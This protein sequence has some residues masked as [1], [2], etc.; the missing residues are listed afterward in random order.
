MAFGKA[1]DSQ[2]GEVNRVEAA[3]ALDQI[4][5]SRPFCNSHQCSGLLKY[6]VEHSLAGEE[7]LLR[8]RVI[9]AEIFGRPPGYEPAEDPVVRLRV[10]DV[11]KRLAQYYQSEADPTCMLVEI[12]P[13]SYRAIFKL[14]A[15]LPANLDGSEAGFLTGTFATKQ[16][17]AT[18][19][20]PDEASPRPVTFT[21]LN[22][23]FNSRISIAI[24]ILLLICATTA[25]V[26]L[27]RA[28]PEK[29]AFRAFWAPWTKSQKPV[30]ISV[31]S[32]AVYRFKFDYVDQYAKDH[33]IES[34]GQEVFLPFKDHETL[35]TSELDPA[36][37]SFVALS[38]V[39]AVSSIVA[40]LTRQNKAFQERFPDDISFAEL[41]VTPSVLVGGFNNPMA[42]ELTRHLEF[43]MRRGPEIDDVLNPGRK[44]SLHVP[45]GTPDTADYAILTRL[46]QR[47]GDA[48]LLSVAGLGGY[49]T[50]AAA[51]LISSPKAVYQL[52]NHLP[53]GWADKNLQVVMK[54]GITDFKVGSPEIVAYR[55]W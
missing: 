18:A 4:L 46:V 31:G 51:E 1:I 41:R 2:S 3:R 34:S 8:E 54:V 49:G 24:T 48:P 35:S 21:G 37:N 22:R 42:M 38:D 9:G 47:N 6:I 23:A 16:G 28:N 40:N 32:N 33:G 20:V 53:K 15:E 17:E 36:Y 11:R 43:V 39:A 45:V 29:G 7:N 25:T 27:L 52:A 14:R 30:I 12:P 44:W 55:S 5:A 19:L 50:L 13:G 10:A 26:L